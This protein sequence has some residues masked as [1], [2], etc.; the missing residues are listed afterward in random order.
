VHKCGCALGVQGSVAGASDA[1]APIPVSHN[2]L[3]IH[4]NTAIR[5]VVSL[6]MDFRH[7]LANCNHLKWLIATDRAKYLQVDSYFL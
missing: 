7:R 6:P 2:K 5:K 4:T 3:N 1:L